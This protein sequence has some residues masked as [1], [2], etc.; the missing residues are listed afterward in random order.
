MLT[1]MDA[2]KVAELGATALNGSASFDDDIETIYEAKILRDCFWLED[3]NSVTLLDPATMFEDDEEDLELLR[4]YEDNAADGDGHSSEE[5]DSDL[6]ERLW[7]VAEYGALDTGPKKQM[8]NGKSSTESSQ[9][10]SSDDDDTSDDSPDEDEDE[11]RSVA[12]E[13]E[14]EDKNEKENIDTTVVNGVDSLPVTR[15]IDLDLDQEK[16]YLDEASEDE[17]EYVLNNQLQNLIDEQIQYVEMAKRRVRRSRPMQ[18]IRDPELGPCRHCGVKSHHTLGHYGDDCPRQ[19]AHRRY[20]ESAF[21]M[22]NIPVSS[23][24]SSRNNPRNSAGS[25]RYNATQNNQN[26]PSESNNASNRY[27]NRRDPSRKRS[28]VDNEDRRQQDHSRRTVGRSDNTGHERLSGNHIRF[29]EQ[30]A[31]QQASARGNNNWRA[32][33]G[34]LPQPTRSGTV[35][36]SRGGGGRQARYDTDFPR[37]SAD[38]LPRPS[39]SGVIDLSS[40]S[41]GMPNRRGPRY[42]GGYSA[43]R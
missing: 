29:Q 23:R 4:Q 20:I 31:P 25:N 7:S 2:P 1:A 3:T 18:C 27:G 42:R 37:G 22:N 16:R 35:N 17:E 41:N 40:L 24:T 8:P 13:S 19:P 43:G 21:N 39:S 30:P 10:P 12:D 32:L 15:V 6:E 11:E 9:L 26:W 5:I 38:E 14:T 34:G 28:R 36:I 33:G